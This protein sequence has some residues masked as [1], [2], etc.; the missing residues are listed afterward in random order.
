MYK[1]PY[2]L[3]RELLPN[4]ALQVGTVV[5]VAGGVA[6]LELPG[7][8]RAQARGDPTVGTRVFFR[9]DLIEGPAPNLPIEIIEI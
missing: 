7:G 4:P 3:L 9:N 2:T 1:N 5:S 6:S 8:G